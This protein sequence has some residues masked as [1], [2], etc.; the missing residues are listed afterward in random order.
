M[1]GRGTTRKTATKREIK[2]ERWMVTRQLPDR[3]TGLPQGC[4]HT[5]R[6][7][8]RGR[9]PDK[10]AFGGHRPREVRPVRDV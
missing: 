8:N 6:W 1:S 9:T 5:R 10:E 2:L 7:R 3:A 4:R